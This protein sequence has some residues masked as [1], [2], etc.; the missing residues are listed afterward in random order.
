MKNLFITGGMF[1]G[2]LVIVVVISQVLDVVLSRKTPTAVQNGPSSK[3]DG[4]ITHPS[5]PG[6]GL[7]SPLLSSA[8]HG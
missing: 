4:G 3:P 6:P 8:Q 7:R 5:Q 2:A 1:L